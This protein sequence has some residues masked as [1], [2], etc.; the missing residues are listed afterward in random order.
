MA[1]KRS[2]WPLHLVTCNPVA[3]KLHS[4]SDAGSLSM[5]LA[6]AKAR[7][8]AKLDL[9]DAEECGSRRAVHR[10]YVFNDSSQV[11]PLA[12]LNDDVMPALAVMSTG[13]WFGPQK[14][15]PGAPRQP[16]T[17]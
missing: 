13:A 5:A 10:L 15:Q 8:R 12:V 1:L 3:D 16:E 11:S 4:L 6:T 17:Y 2:I 14:Q 7:E 9:W